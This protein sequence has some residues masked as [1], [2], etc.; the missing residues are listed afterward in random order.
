MSE[1]HQ[2]REIE[3]PDDGEDAESAVDGSRR[4]TRE[5]LPTL[6]IREAVLREIITQGFTESPKLTRD[7]LSLS[8]AFIRAFT[9]E[10]AHRSAR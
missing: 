8:S 3:E 1:S 6:R 4:R 7:A 10:A 2:S 5:T 9:A